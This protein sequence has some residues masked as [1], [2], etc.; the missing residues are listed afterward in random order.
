MCKK[1]LTPFAFLGATVLLLSWF[2]LTQEVRAIPSFARKYET[3]C[4]TC[5]VAF[6]KLNAFGEAFRNNGYRFP[7]ADEEAV[8]QK[9]VSLGAPA[10]KKVWP[11]AIWPSDIP[12]SA[13]LALLVTNTYR[14]LPDN[15]VSN[16]FVVPNEVE[17]FTGGTLGES[18]SFYG[19]ITLLDQNEFG[20]LHRL[21]G[22]FNRVAGTPLLNI[23]LGG[24]EPRATPFSSHRRLVLTDYLLN[25]VAASMSLLQAGQVRFGHGHGATPFSLSSTQRGIELWG[26]QDG[27]GGGGLEWAFGITNGNGLGFRGAA[28][29]EVEEGGSGDHLDGPHLQSEDH[30]PPEEEHDLENN[31]R[32]SIET[33]DDTSGKDVYARLSYKFFGLGRTGVRGARATDAESWVD[34]SIRLGFFAVRGEGLD[35][36]ISRETERY[37]RYGGDFDIWFE[38]LNLFG[39]YLFGRNELLTHEGLQTFNLDSWFVEADYVLLPWIIPAFRYEVADV[40]PILR[41]GIPQS[42]RLPIIRRVVPHVTFLLRSNVKLAFDTNIYLNDYASNLYLFELDFA[43]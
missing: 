34:N 4:Q 41:N 24:F 5:H 18:V 32:S 38:D 31:H 7:V 11:K 6:P 3:S 28:H 15:P 21:F 23:K 10:Y 30:G 26:V 9:P 43:F 40:Q 33:L 37:R 36:L 14:V 17:F 13:P 29:E 16:D 12:P 25:N 19:G 1:N 35:L 22:Q 27:P 20:G 2:G 39:A 8:K 42:N